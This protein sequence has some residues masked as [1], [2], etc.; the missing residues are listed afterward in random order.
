M[1]KIKQEVLP[2]LAA[3]L[4]LK[5]AF[6]SATHLMLMHASTTHQNGVISV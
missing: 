2:E 3:T 6:H 5:K 4:K 1:H